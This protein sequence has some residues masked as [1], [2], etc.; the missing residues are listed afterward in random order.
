M[1]QSAA[2]RVGR[3]RVYSSAPEDRA[4][5]PASHVRPRCDGPPGTCLRYLLHEK[6]LP[7]GWWLTRP[8]HRTSDAAAPDYRRTRRAFATMGRKSA[9]RIARTAAHWENPIVRIGVLKKND[10]IVAA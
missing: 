5:R 4:G 8:P 6:N 3:P 10:G 7:T 2:S 1:G 9:T